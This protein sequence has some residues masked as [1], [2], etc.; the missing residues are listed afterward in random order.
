MKN[1]ITSAV[2]LLAETETMGKYLFGAYND[3][4]EAISFLSLPE[5]HG[6]FIKLLIGQ[7]TIMG[8]N[9]LKATPDIFPDGGRICVTHHPENVKLPAIAAK[10]IEEAIELAKERAEKRGENKVYVIGGANLMKQCL[11]ENLLEEIELTLTFGHKKDVQNPVYLDF[12]LE[13]W[14]II[15]DSGLLTSEVSE[16]KKLNYR[17]LTLR[18]LK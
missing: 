15:K 2:V 9:T 17:F 1:I 12:N 8:A 7:Q 13:N 10:N 14:K 5:D 4:G 3:K 18:S 16:P 11:E 6:V